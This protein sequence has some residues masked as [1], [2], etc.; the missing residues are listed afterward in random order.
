M[1]TIGFNLYR[2]KSLDGTRTKINANLI[3]SQNAGQSTGG[4]YVFKDKTVVIKKT[5]YYWLEEIDLARVS[6]LYEPVRVKVKP[7]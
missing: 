1:G 5:Y 6:T 7:K 4:Y 3:P 2:S